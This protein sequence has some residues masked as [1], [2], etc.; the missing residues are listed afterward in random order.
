MNENIW[1][2]ERRYYTTNLQNEPDFFLEMSRQF[3]WTNVLTQG[4]QS[5][6]KYS[7]IEQYLNLI[8]PIPGQNVDK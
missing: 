7:K 4:S 2:T 6:Y 8:F 1:L 5:M 3:N